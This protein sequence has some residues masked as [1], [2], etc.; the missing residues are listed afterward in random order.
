M[1]GYCGGTHEQGPDQAEDRVH[2]PFGQEE[3]L[4]VRAGQR[5]QSCGQDQIRREDPRKADAGGQTGKQTGRYS[6]N[7]WIAQG[8]G[9]VTVPATSP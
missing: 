6:L 5:Q 2:N 4:H 1:A 3:V 8:N 7:Q 9:R